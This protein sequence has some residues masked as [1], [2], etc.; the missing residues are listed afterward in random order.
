MAS[1]SLSITQGIRA[2]SSTLDVIRLG[3][4][5]SKSTFSKYR[6]V[7]ACAIPAPFPLPW[8]SSLRSSIAIRCGFSPPLQYGV[9]NVP[10]T[11]GSSPPPEKF[12][13][14]VSTTSRSAESNSSAGM[15]FLDFS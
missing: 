11:F 4:V 7:H 10:V 3:Y 6:L 9:T 13:P 2:F 12:F 15:I 8:L 1:L 5:C 14:I